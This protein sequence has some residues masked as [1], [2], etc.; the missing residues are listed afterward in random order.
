MST[1]SYSSPLR[2]RQAAGTRTVILEALG[3]EL[4]DGGIEDFSVARLARRAGVAERTVYRH[5]PTREALLDGL[6]EWY[7]EH[8]GD[9][10]EGVSAEAI[11]QTIAQVFADFDEHE[12]LARAVL[13]SP[14][15]RELRRHARAAR[16]ARLDAALAPT[17]DRAVDPERAAAA[18]ALIFA[19][20]SAR[21]WQA[22]RDEGGLDGAAAGRAVARAIQLILDDTTSP[23][24]STS[25]KKE[26]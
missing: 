7:N 10:P 20:C 6:S 19:L 26:P 16:L 3:T 5:F 11:P 22:M 15:G 25:P 18:R 4:A 8:V 12:S 1:R 21:T 14:G 9:F 17:L 24:T 23:S 13:A 2:D